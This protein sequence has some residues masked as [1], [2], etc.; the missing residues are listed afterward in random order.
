MLCLNG[1]IE[2]KDTSIEIPFYIFLLYSLTYKRMMVKILLMHLSIVVP[3]FNEEK[4]LSILTDE[5]KAAAENLDDT[6]LI[7]VDDNS[8]D[9]SIDVMRRLKKDNTN[10]L[11][12]VLHRKSRGGLSAAL[13][14]GFIASKGDIIVSIDSDLQNDPADIPLLLSY[15][16]RY[17]IAIGWRM[18]RH[19]TLIKKASSKI[20]NFIRNSVTH[21]NIHDTGCTLKAYKREFLLK[22]KLFDGLHRFL[23]TLLKLE[24]AKVIEI[25]VKHRKRR[26]GKS[27]YH[28]LNRLIG[29]LVDL[30]AVRWM[31]KRHIDISYTEL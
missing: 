23:P 9:R 18:K 20:A 13:A 12:R 1:L 8:S 14:A 15:I 7:F 22:L 21:E 2:N 17:D 29:P 25:P 27:K 3:V 30:L 31:Q 5:I 26:Y 28:L 11:I 6:E 4:S 16:G 19:D 24:G 10:L